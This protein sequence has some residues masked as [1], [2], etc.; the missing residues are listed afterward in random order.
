MRS[1]TCVWQVFWHAASCLLMLA[2][3]LRALVPSLRLHW[4]KCALQYDE[5]PPG[6]EDSVCWLLFLLLFF[7]PQ[8]QANTSL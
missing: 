2:L 4:C 7:F 8:D 3:L 1:A 5:L 6:R